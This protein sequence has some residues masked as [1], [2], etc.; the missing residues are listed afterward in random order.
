MPD[1][2]DI[3]YAHLRTVRLPAAGM[4]EAAIR[5]LLARHCFAAGLYAQVEYRFAPRCRADIYVAGVVIEVK[6]RRPPTADVR[7]HAVG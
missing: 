5:D 4:E 3:L 7:N 6:K 2:I 1:A